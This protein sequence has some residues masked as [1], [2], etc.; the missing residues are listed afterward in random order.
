ME[1]HNYRLYSLETTQSLFELR[2]FLRLWVTLFIIRS[3]TKKAKMHWPSFILRQDLLWWRPESAQSMSGLSE[4][5]GLHFSRGVWLC[6]NSVASRKLRRGQSKAS[7]NP[8]CVWFESTPRCRGIIYDLVAAP[9]FS[10]WCRSRLLKVKNC[11]PLQSCSQYWG[12]VHVSRIFILF[13]ETTVTES[14]HLYYDD[15]QGFRLSVGEN[16]F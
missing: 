7:F 14:I 2:V 5:C 9:G 4:D 3:W 6:H 12:L 13:G 16:K 1:Y 11:R 10:R 8:R 15:Y